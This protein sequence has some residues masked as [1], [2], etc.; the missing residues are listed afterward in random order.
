MAEM[1]GG[2]AAGSGGCF[3]E[4][5][6]PVNAKGDSV[7][8]R[9]SE[10]TLYDV[11]ITPRKPIRTCWMRTPPAQR[12]SERK[13]ASTTEQPPGA[14]SE[15]AYPAQAAS[16]VQGQRLAIDCHHNIPVHQHS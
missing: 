8:N 16:A 2:G 10:I 14:S 1:G 11:P 13:T 4:D 7:S 15:S 3:G 5:G 6:R 9:S 12:K